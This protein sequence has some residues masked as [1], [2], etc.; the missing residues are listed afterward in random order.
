MFFSEK[1]SI[2][3]IQYWNSDWLS[4]R[5]IPRLIS[6]RKSTWRLHNVGN[7]VINQ[8]HNVLEFANKHHV[9]ILLFQHVLQLSSYQFLVRF[10]PK[11]YCLFWNVFHS[12][13]Y[14]TIT[15]EE[16]QKLNAYYYAQGLFKFPESFLFNFW[17]VY[18]KYQSRTGNAVT[19][20]LGGMVGT[21]RHLLSSFETSIYSIKK[22]EECVYEYTW[23][24]YFVY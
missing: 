23:S 9:N 10:C 18:F 11:C 8:I 19:K 16:G 14:V 7:Y 21:V 20:Q 24:F 17:E 12:I 6:Q 5:R 3:I 22:Y 13:S 2:F 4:A 15:L 1:H